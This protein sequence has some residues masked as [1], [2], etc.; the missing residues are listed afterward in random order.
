MCGKQT[1]FVVFLNTRHTTREKYS[2]QSRND[3]NDDGD[4]T[5]S[6]SEG[7]LLDT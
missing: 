1:T 6:D 3:D 7:W 5:D 4:G 2:K